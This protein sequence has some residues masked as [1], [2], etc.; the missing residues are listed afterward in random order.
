M[1]GEI[2]EYFKG[3]RN[4][5]LKVFEP[6]QNWRGDH[7]LNRLRGIYFEIGDKIIIQQYYGRD[8]DLIINHYN[9][10]YVLLRHQLLAH[11]RRAK[12]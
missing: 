12:S 9:N 7:L 1:I 10:K 6:I 11:F 3:P 2:W 4:D 8:C 5:P